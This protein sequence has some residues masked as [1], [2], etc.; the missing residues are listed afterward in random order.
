MVRY[1]ESRFDRRRKKRLSEREE[2]EMKAAKLAEKMGR[3]DPRTGDDRRQSERRKM[4][5][6]A[7]EVDDWLKRNGISTGDR[8]HNDRRSGDRR[9]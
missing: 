3:Q 5:M 8:R 2:A 1:P 4:V 6:S 9:R 7:D